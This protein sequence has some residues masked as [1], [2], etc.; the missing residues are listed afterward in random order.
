A[1]DGPR[2]GGKGGGV[3]LVGVPRARGHVQPRAGDARGLSG[4]RV[5]GRCGHRGSPRCTVLCSLIP[6]P[7]RVSTKRLFARSGRPLAPVDEIPRTPL[8]KGRSMSKK[9]FGKTVLVLGLLALVTSA[10][11]GA[12]RTA[13]VPSGEP[14]ISGVSYATG[15]GAPYLSTK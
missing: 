4:R 1:D 7:T 14:T 12:A 2:G 11:V 9:A 13:G 3:H 15:A 5:R 8:T 6:S 10:A